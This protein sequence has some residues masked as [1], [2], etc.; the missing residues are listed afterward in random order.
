ML[1]RDLSSWLI[2]AGFLVTDNRATFNNQSSGE[3]GVGFLLMFT[4]KDAPEVN[5]PLAFD[6][7]GDQQSQQ[8]GQSGL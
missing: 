3:V 8:G 6:V 7:L 1:H 5:I 2:S 4:L